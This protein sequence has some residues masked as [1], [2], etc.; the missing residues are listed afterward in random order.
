MRICKFVFVVVVLIVCQSFRLQAQT[1]Q[2]LSS[3]EIVSWLYQL[4][5]D[6]E[7]RDE[8]V[9]EIRKRGINFP[10]TDGMRS[11]VATKSGN[12]SLLR[13]TLEEAERRRVNPV[14]STLPSTTEGTELLERTRNV[15]LAAAGAMPDFIVKQ[16]IRRSVAYGTTTNWIPQDTLSIAVGYRANQGE[17]Y[18]LL[19]V[20]GVPTGE[21]VQ[22]SK[23]YSKYVKGAT[24]SGVEYISALAD[25]FKPES[26]TEF[27]MVDTDVIQGRRTIVYEYSVPKDRSQLTLSVGDTG[28]STIA[29]S[30]GRMWIDRELDR[31]LRFEQ[32]A[33]EIPA[34]FPISAATS[35]IDYDWVSINE[36]KYL[37]PSHSEILM[38]TI[39]PKMVLQ[40]RNDVRF[41]SYQKFGAELKVVDEVGEDDEPT[42]DTKPPA[43]PRIDKPATAS[44]STE[45]PSTDKPSD[46]APPVP[47]LKPKKPTL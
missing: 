8:L 38:T 12:D 35:L 22:E 44:Q 5:R 32:I 31:V 13:R 21:D 4:P 20:N 17:Q 40:S 1:T 43:K 30:Q 28:A 23:D 18:K 2:P 19:T 46:G 14:G 7:K 6:P 33:T 37:L 41:R 42:R 15:T 45:T 36:H 39:Q 16:L 27:R 47:T 24:S 10:L 9:E 11:L 26:Q 34:G 25:I 29:G 3:K